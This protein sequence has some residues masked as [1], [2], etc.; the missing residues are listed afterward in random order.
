MHCWMYPANTK[1]SVGAEGQRNADCIVTNC[2]QIA[3]PIYTP[4]KADETA[5][6]SKTTQ[7]DQKLVQMADHALLK[8]R[9]AVGTK[10][11]PLLLVLCASGLNQH[12]WG[13]RSNI[14]Y[15]VYSGS[16]KIDSSVCKIC[17]SQNKDKVLN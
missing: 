7:N 10:E 2:Y 16:F 13:K 6:P 12:P 8:S 9:T 14:T 15:S 3:G 5:I 1:W 4:V 17:R 11:F